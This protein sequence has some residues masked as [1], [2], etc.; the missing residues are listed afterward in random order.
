MSGNQ[1]APMLC[2]PK[3]DWHLCTV[4]NCHQYNENM[5]KDVT[6]MPD[7]DS[8]WEDVTHERYRSKIDMSNAYKQVR[9]VSDDIWNTAFMTIQGTYTSAVMQQGNCN[10]LAMFQRLMASIFQDII[11]TFMHIYIDDIFVFSNSIEKHQQHLCI[12]FDCL[13]EQALYLKWKKCE[14]YT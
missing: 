1:A 7:Q 4:I 14:L 5:I 10:A 9:I 13:K 11:E 3:K 2:L 6:P 12:I 8:I